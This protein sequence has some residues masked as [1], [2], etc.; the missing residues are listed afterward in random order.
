VALFFAMPGNE[1]LADDLA[2]LTSCNVGELELRHFPDGETYV[3]ITADVRREDIFI[4]CTLARPDVQFLPLAF[5][6]ATVRG[7]GAARVQLVAPYLAYMRQDRIFL[8]GEALTSRLFAELLQ[9]HFDGLIT[10][11]PHLHRHASLDEVYDIATTVIHAA[12]LLAS[13]ISEHVENPVVIGPD[14][15]SA[16]W[17][18]A[19]ARD[20]G[21]VWAVF[22]KERR[23]DRDVRI[24][25]PRL[26]SFRSC[27]PVLVDDIVSS[28]ATMKEALRLLRREGFPPAYCL[29]VHGRPGRRT[30]RSLADRCAGF[31]TSNTVPNEHAM[32]DVAPLI[33]DVLVASAARRRE[34]AS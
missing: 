18:E 4:V 34:L 32:F 26:K 13:W 17:V 30:V 25:A 3:R 11:D 9:K 6:A 5:T 23:G 7:L 21:A 29:A 28:A 14:E 15:E 12:P 24:A 20:A 27:T 22:K 19:I 16:Q 31:I 8:P 2:R 1:E 33:A 10:V